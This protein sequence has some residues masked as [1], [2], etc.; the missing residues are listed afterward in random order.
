MLPFPQQKVQ[1]AMA[2][3]TGAGY[4]YYLLAH[5]DDPA[6]PP[7]HTGTGTGTVQTFSHLAKYVHHRLQGTSYSLGYHLLEE[8]LV[9]ESM[10]VLR[11]V[12]YLTITYHTIPYYT[13]P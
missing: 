6:V 8:E 9:N 11:C 4:Q 5:G 2:A 7:L 10:E 12:P 1:E 13:I 3:L